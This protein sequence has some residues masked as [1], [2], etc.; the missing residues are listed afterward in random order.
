MNVCHVLLAIDESGS[1]YR[2]ADDV[3]GGFNS[4][5]ST[6]AADTDTEYLVTVALFNTRVWWLTADDEGR[7][8][9]VPLAEVPQL[10]EENYV[11]QRGT[12]LNDAIGHLVTRQAG[13]SIG[14]GD[15]V[16]VVVNTDGE[17][18]SSNEWKHKDVTAL[19]DDH[20]GWGF[21]FLGAGPEA[22]QHGNT[23]GM[24]SGQTSGTRA[25]TH[26]LWGSMGVNTTAYASGLRS[27]AEVAKNVAADS[28][29][30]DDE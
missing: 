29:A 4:Y 24:S 12:A 5:L 17:E 9:E 19:I 3:R 7:A 10:T 15:R 2:L 22:W 14:D 30:A 26:A 20:P 18:N 13:Q 11:P 6:L 23:Y 27:A 25:G 8:R 21:V 16:L 28:V 1:M